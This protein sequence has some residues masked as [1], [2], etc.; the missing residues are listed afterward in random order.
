MSQHGK[1][2]FQQHGDFFEC[3][4]A[5]GH[6]GRFQRGRCYVDRLVAICV[7]S[8]PDTQWFYDRLYRF[9]KAPYE[10]RFGSLVVVE[11]RAL[12]LGLQCW[13]DDAKFAGVSSDG[14]NG[15]EDWVGITKVSKS[16]KS[17]A[18]WGRSM[19]LAA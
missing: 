3:F 16:I 9:D 7:P 18:W 4:K 14:D 8:T 10:K 19:S 13:Y 5:A 2:D 15:E 1:H 17:H 6:V 12:K 11:A